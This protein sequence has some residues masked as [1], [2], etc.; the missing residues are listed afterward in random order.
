MKVSTVSATFNRDR[1][2][3][4]GIRTLINQNRPPDEIII[5]DDGSTDNTRHDCDTLGRECKA[6]GIEFKYL[7]LNYPGH[8]ISCYPR[9]VGFKQS[10]GDVVIFTEPEC[11][12]IGD[13]VKQ[14]LE[15]LEQEPNRTVIAS[16]IWTMGERVWKDITDFSDPQ[17]IIHHP[18]AMLVTGNMQNTNAPDSDWG[19]T[20]SLNC[21]AGCLIG[22]K[23]E[24][25]ED[26]GGFDESFEG[27][28]GDD[29]NLY[30][31][32]ALYGK[33]VKGYDD[34][35]VIH[36][37]HEKN[38]PYNIYDMAEKNLKAGTER[39]KQGE[40]KVNNESDWG[41]L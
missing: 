30:D 14:T 36:Q 11:L 39:I 20:G 40:Y 7:Y 10:T 29:F 26:V 35:G 18:Y 22:L 16:Q 19:I 25:F 12:H 38:Y 9:N 2:M 5:V 8:R 13:T 31:R 6:K 15:K 27:H 33:G 32:L 24:W 17:K 34:I 37:W 3:V 1:Q 4:Q 21:M 28:G 41:I 23:R